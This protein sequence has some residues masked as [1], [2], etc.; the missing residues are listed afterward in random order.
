VLNK[1]VYVKKRTEKDIWQNLHEFVLEEADN[2]HKTGV[3]QSAFF[4]K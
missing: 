1:Q 2:A 4:K 3:A